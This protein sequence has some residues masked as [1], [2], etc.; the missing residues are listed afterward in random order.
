MVSTMNRIAI[1]AGAQPD[2]A[3]DAIN[4]D[5]ALK[6]RLAELQSAGS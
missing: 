1:E 5:V 4:K 3:H 6:A 2:Q